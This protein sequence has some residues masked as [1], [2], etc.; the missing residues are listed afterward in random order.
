MIWAFAQHYHFSPEI[1]R[2]LSFPHLKML[3][4]AKEFK[5][6]FASEEE[7]VIFF[8]SFEDAIAYSQKIKAEKCQQPS[9]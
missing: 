2:R 4:N 3:M 9:H 8:A 5:D 7:Q 1:T 6:P